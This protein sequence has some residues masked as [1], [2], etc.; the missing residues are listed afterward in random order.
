MIGVMKVFGACE[1]DKVLY[2]FQKG[3]SNWTVS[4]VGSGNGPM[5]KLTWGDGDNSR[6]I[7][8]LCSL[9]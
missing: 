5:Y 4:E 6:K 8:A 3:A 2:Q 7:Q 1:D 9:R